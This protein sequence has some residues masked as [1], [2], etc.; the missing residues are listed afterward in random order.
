MPEIIILLVALMAVVAGVPV[1][2]I[3][4]RARRKPPV[5]SAYE[6]HVDN[7]IRTGDWAELDRATDEIGNEDSKE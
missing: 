6:Q 1:T 7:F 5:L 2:V 3:I 4:L